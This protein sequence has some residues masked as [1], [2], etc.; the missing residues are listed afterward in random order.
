M[1]HHVLASKMPPVY[2]SHIHTGIAHHAAVMKFKT[3]RPSGGM[4]MK[5]GF[6]A[7]GSHT[8]LTVRKGP[9]DVILIEDGSWL[10]IVLGGSMGPP[11]YSAKCIL[12]YKM[13]I[14]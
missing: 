14:H 7:G 12:I 1:G 8:G 13:Y 9:V 4:V 6:T 2:V 10:D 11:L 5:D 3:K